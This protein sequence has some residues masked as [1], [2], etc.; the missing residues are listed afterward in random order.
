[1]SI[2]I[3]LPKGRLLVETASMLEKAG[4]RL[5]GY[6]AS[7]HNYR[8]PSVRF[9]A[10]QI[11]VFQEKDIPIQVA[12]GNYD[13]GICGLD[14]IEEL[15][16]KYA[17]NAL[18]RVKDLG[19]GR[20][21]LFT[22]GS[23]YGNPL[24]MNDLRIQDET[25]RIASE[26]PNIAESFALNQRFRRFSVYPLWGG[27]DAYPPESATLALVSAGSDGKSLNNGLT[28][29]VKVLDYSANLIA[30]RQS[31]ERKD[32]SEI[33]L[34]LEGIRPQVET[35]PVATGTSH[36]RPPP[37]PT[38]R[39]ANDIIRL[40]LPDGHQQKFTV[41]LLERAGIIIDDY[42]STTGNRRPIVKLDGVVAKVIR[43]QDMPLQVANGNFDLA[44]TGKD[45][46]TDHLASFPSSPVRELVDLKSAWVRIVAVV[47]QDVPADT[48]YELRRI[49][50][51]K[52]LPLRVASEY[53]SLAD[54]YARDNHLGMYRI[55]P[56]WGA[57][58][59]FLPEDADLL[60]ENTETGSTIARHHLKIIDTLFESTARLIGI[61][62]GKFSRLKQARI[63][64]LA[65]RLADAV[66]N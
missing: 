14:W 34:T 2:R 17:T 33:L 46:L 10:L 26:Y 8:L 31:W 1:M 54:K 44:I 22:A 55:I 24:S 58:E 61:K 25:V 48:I 30:N 35:P 6:D 53:T 43:P 20:G 19:Y 27:A 57:T 37:F 56:T 7:L 38:T 16:V 15:S 52:D 11:K 36:L 23:R 12:I 63:N 64:S 21:A 50:A 66:K 4:W 3:A 47:S 28:P 29:L 42:P 49:C 60:I 51:N 5:S 41:E 32:L 62:D 18:V 45:W 59:A 9:P 40:A 65:K 39:E 13:L